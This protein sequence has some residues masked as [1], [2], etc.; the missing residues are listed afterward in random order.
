M[1]YYKRNL[2][3]YSKKAGR[4][5]ILQHGV[6]NLLI[7]ACYDREK[8]PTLEEAIDW[9]WAGTTEEI[10]AVKFVLSKFF[11]LENG[12]YV[13]GRIQE[14][15]A[16]YHEFC[17]AQEAKGKLGGRPKGKANGKENKPA[18]FSDKADGNP[19]ESQRVPKITLTTNQ[20]P[21]TNITGTNVP[22]VGTEAPTPPE[23]VKPEKTPPCPHQ[24]IIDLY[25]E[26]LPAGTMVRVW[27]D[28]RET[29][30]RTR[31]REDKKRQSLAWWE[32]FFKYVDKSDFL[33]GR[34][35]AQP[36]RTQFVVSLDWLVN[37]QN[38]A[39]VIEG[40]YHEAQS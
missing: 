2:G 9:T 25:H 5:S 34:V 19:D 33:M 6:Y 18:G 39:K 37:P 22:V 26:T 1:H 36:G 13:Q 32:K 28:L 11:K 23:K 15:I 20:E 24:D 4:L 40:K 3:D 10:E 29:H 21:L 35:P 7:D 8:F 12:V 27:N 30:L 31:W 17:A 16:E 38:M 14:E